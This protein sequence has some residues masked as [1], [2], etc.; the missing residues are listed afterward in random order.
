MRADD[1]L[2]SGPSGRTPAE[3]AAIDAR[4]AAYPRPLSAVQ[5]RAIKTLAAGYFHYTR[6]G[7]AR[8]DA[9]S[10]TEYFSTQTVD[11]LCNRGMARRRLVGRARRITVTPAGKREAARH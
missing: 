3:R 8:H 1:H 2:G 9:G 7:W 6:A 5:V 10:C 4:A 11:A